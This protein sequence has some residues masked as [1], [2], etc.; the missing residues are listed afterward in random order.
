MKAIEE[1]YPQ[2]RIQDAAYNYQ[3]QVESGERVVVGVNKFQQKETGRADL[4][5]VNP[6]VENSQRQKLA[7]VKA[8]RCDTDAVQALEALGKD[9]RGSANLMP[10]ILECVRR[11]AT[12][13]EICGVLRGE[14]GEYQ[15]KTV[16]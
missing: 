4:L 13:G 7:A 1:G 9:A 5:K 12:L 16:V 14:F 11:Y 10:S 3:K 15:P 2:K 6:E 8:E